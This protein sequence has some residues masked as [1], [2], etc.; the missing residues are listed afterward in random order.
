MN[1]YEWVFQ[2]S[3]CSQQCEPI[4][5]LSSLRNAFKPRSQG[6]IQNTAMQIGS[7]WKASD[8]KE[9]IGARL[10]GAL[11][12][13]PRAQSHLPSAIVFLIPNDFNHASLFFWGKKGMKIFQ[14][15]LKLYLESAA[16]CCGMPVYD[17][18]CQLL[19][20]TRSGVKTRELCL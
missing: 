18:Q 10:F 5:F 12:S 4:I 15:A 9:K 16:A 14:D 8:I 19:K 3:L 7:R 1:T 20:Y 6:W 2:Q 11:I 13:W 17:D